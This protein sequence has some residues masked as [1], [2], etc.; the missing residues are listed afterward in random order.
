MTSEKPRDVFLAAC[1]ALA[2][3]LVPFGFRSR[4]QNQ[5]L[6]RRRG[7]WQHRVY[8]ASSGYNRAGE[9]V[10]LTPTV[11]VSNE[12]LKQWRREN[13]GR[14]DGF[15]TSRMLYRFAPESVV[16][17]TWDLVDP[18]A[19]HGV[20]DTVTSILTDRAIPW[21][22]LFDDR[23]EVL[24]E[25]NFDNEILGIDAMAELMVFLGRTDDAVAVV[26]E[27]MSREPWSQFDVDAEAFKNLRELADR[28]S[29]DFPVPQGRDPA[30]EAA[31]VARLRD[32]LDAYTRS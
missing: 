22:D 3:R 12:T 29:L 21:F 9:Y 30:V 28:F 10:A 5:E 11:L 31:A 4:R 13:G 1:D 2:S 20:L 14:S 17:V 24:T 8:F 15:V 19:R 7:A 23:L 25:W 32:A 26:R 16:G 27:A 18:T 6:I